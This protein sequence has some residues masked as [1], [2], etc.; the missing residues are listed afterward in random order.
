MVIFNANSLELPTDTLSSQT[1]WQDEVK[2]QVYVNQNA[3]IETCFFGDSITSMLG[4]TLGQNTFNFAIG[5]M[6]TISQLE[7]LKYLTAAKVRCNKAII[8]LGTND[9]IYKTMDEQ[10]ISNLKQIVATVRQEMKAKNIVLIPAF[11]STFE[12]AHDLTMAG[13]IAKVEQIQVLTRQ[14]ATAEKLPIA[15]KEIQPLFESKALKATL[16]SDGVHLN[17][18]GKRIYRS[19][20]LKITGTY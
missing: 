10:F 16:T 4:N 17:T 12:A 15:E 13:P 3:K 2:Y 20:L 6:T 14:V 8:A 9:A 19:A 11:Y 7:Q 18:E 5:G 1:W